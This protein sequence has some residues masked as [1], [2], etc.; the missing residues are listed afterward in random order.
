LPPGGRSLTTSPAGTRKSG[1]GSATPRCTPPRRV[2]TR[3]WCAT[4]WPRARTRPCSPT[5]AIRQSRAVHSAIAPRSS[6]SPSAPRAVWRRR[7]WRREAGP[8]MMATLSSTLS[9]SF[10]VSARLGP[11]LHCWPPRGRFG[12]RRRTEASTG[13]NPR[14]AA[15]NAQTTSQQTGADCGRRLPRFPRERR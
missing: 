13:M 7:V 5:K 15:E 12:R 6:L 4:Y 10:R 14:H 3:V 9:R 2:A 1:P 11:A 8:C